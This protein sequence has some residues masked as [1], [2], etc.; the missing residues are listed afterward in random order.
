[1]FDD[2][3]GFRKFYNFLV[4]CE[5]VAKAQLRNALK[6]WDILCVLISRLPNGLIDRWNITAYKIRKRKETE[7]NLSDLIKFMD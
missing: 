3:K 1:M 7:P 4:K 2:A 6:T 5:S